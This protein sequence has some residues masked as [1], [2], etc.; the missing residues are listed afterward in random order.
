MNSRT[1][2]LYGKPLAVFQDSER[3]AE[4]RF[5]IAED[6]T[7]DEAQ[8]KI[9]TG[10]VGYFEN[11]TIHLPDDLTGVDF[12]QPDTKGVLHSLE[13]IESLTE[14]LRDVSGLPNL[15]GQ[16]LS[17]EALKRLFVFFYAETKAIQNSLRLAL[18]RILNERVSW[19]HIFDT[20]LFSPKPL[21]EA[22]NEQDGDEDE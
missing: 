13:S 4:A 12:L 20:D 5:D 7:Q 1:L 8:R 9:L 16:T 3:D 6:D 19:E 22:Q 15:Q 21:T 10:Q 11:A 14:I 2:D 18:E 17:G